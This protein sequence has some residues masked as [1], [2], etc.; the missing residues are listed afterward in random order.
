METNAT[1]SVPNAKKHYAQ[2]MKAHIAHI[3][4]RI[5]AAKNV[6]VPQKQHYIV[7]LKRY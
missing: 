1:V 5:S 4:L 7:S 2:K 3:I 6:L